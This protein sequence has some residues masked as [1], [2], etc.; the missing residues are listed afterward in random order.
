[1]LFLFVIIRHTS[2]V[3]YDDIFKK[4]ATKIDFTLEKNEFTRFIYNK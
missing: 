2:F 1:M 3:N 4:T